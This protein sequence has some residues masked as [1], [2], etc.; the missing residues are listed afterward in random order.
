MEKARYK[1]L[2]IIIIIIE[3]SQYQTWIFL[4]A[5]VLNILQGPHSSLHPKK[6]EFD[7]CFIIHSKYF[8]DLNKLTS[9]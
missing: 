7:N 6:T 3:S 2:I 4:Q 9:S 8:Q 5:E 1:F